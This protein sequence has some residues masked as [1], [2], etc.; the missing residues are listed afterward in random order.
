MNKKNK[1]FTTIELI[2][3]F[4]LASV[5][6]LI[7]FNIILI[8]KDNLSKVNAKTNMLVEKDN[9]S[10]NI[11][12]RFKEKE[13]SSIT[14]CDEGDKCYEFKYSDDTSDKLIYS[15]TDKSIT[16]NNYTFDIIDGIT[17]EEPTITEHY[18]TMSSTTYNG[19]F[20]I[21]IPIKLDNKDYS[22][23][24]VKHFN[25]DSLVIDFPKYEY[26]SDGNKYTVMEYLESTGT[27][28]IDTGIKHTGNDI[29]ETMIVS[30]TKYVSSG[31]YGLIST[32][33]SGYIY[34]NLYFNTAKKIRSYWGSGS[35]MENSLNI[36]LNTKYSIEH[37]YDL[38]GSYGDDHIRS[39]KIND[40][41]VSTSFN[42]TS[43]SNPNTFKIF[44]RGDLNYKSYMKL[45][46][47]KLYINGNL[48]RDYIPVIDSTERP[49]LFD[50]VSKECYYNQGTGEFLYG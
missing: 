14:M 4:T 39:L 31:E 30:F 3:S 42:G 7:L 33:T 15:N 40:T 41:I 50:K 38:N 47:L 16:F 44:C 10:Y 27:Q 46:V 12:K 19:Y 28:Y 1:G 5:I 48:V 32:W 26:D 43:T 24:V 37:I 49:C 23:K 20:I 22:I 34:S 8:L 35:N 9:L 13:L 45:Y 6:M 18:D 29:K 11:N 36:E 2:T 17:V 25:T 21:H